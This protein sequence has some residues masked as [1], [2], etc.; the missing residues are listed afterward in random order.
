[1]Q[2]LRK[3]FEHG[4]QSGITSIAEKRLES[5]RIMRWCQRAVFTLVNVSGWSR[6]KILENLERSAL[7]VTRGLS[8]TVW[9][10]R[11][12]F[13]IAKTSAVRSSRKRLETKRISVR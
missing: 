5:Q 8:E 7:I 13:N 12:T 11:T 4:N 2:L 3:N 10:F 9:S 1:M 6:A